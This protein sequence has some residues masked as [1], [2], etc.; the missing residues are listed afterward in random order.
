MEILVSLTAVL[1]G[2][3]QGITGFGSGIVIM[4]ILPMFFALPQSAGISTAI[5]MFDKC[6]TAFPRI[7]NEFRI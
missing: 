5:C 1:A 6:Y 3:V 7:C 4:M 2:I